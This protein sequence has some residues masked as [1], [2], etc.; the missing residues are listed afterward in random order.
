[1]VY[2]AKDP[3]TFDELMD[4]PIDFS[5]YAMN[6]LKIDRLTQ[7][8]LVG[9]VY[10][11]LKGTCTSS[12]KLKYNME[13]CFKALIDKLDWKNPEE[14]RC[15]FELTN[16]LPLK[17]RPGHLT[18]A[19]DYFF[20]N[21]LEFLKSFD[22]EKN[23]TTS[24]TKTKASRYEIVGIE[25]TVPT[26][27]SPIK[28]GYEKDP[29]KGIKHWGESH[30]LW[31][32]SQ[33]NKFSK[34]NVYSTQKILGVKSVSVK[35]LLWEH[36]TMKPDPHDPNAPKSLYNTKL[37]QL[38]HRLIYLPCVM[39]WSV[40]NR[41]GC[42]EAIDEMLTIKLCVAVYADD[43][44][45][46]KKMIKF[47]LCG[48]AFSWTLLEFAKRALDTTTLRELINSEGMLILE[49]PEPGVPRVAIL[50]PREHRCGICMKGWVA[51][52]YARGRLRGC[53]I[54]SLITG[55]GMLGYLSTW[56]EFT[57]FHCRELITSSSN[58][59][60][61]MMM[62]SVEMTQVGYVTACFGSRMF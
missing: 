33:I 8:I 27:W 7:E 31:Y 44:L 13:E 61:E 24:I 11:M 38:L 42:G 46:T 32:R 16:P 15:P 18:I 47:K 28:Y 43:E 6:Q 17:G 30:K 19:T 59:S 9:P 34:H 3:L 52:R 4:T 53:L 26:L 41:M 40:L 39:D 21:D 12:I 51:W 14:D 48:R 25:D 50:K 55:I 58:N 37:S 57:V 2:A 10:N 60:Q 62:S 35:K 22:P 23:Y 45:R 1:M 20:N 49:V 29:E 36:M 5:K 54:G 56:L